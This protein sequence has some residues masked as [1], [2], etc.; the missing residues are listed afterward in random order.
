MPYSIHR[1]CLPLPATALPRPPLLPA[2][3]SD[4]LYALAMW[5]VFP[6]AGGGRAECMPFPA[7]S[8]DSI[9]L[10]A[11]CSALVGGSEGG[12]RVFKCCLA[13]WGDLFGPRR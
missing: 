9:L 4:M 13:G 12:G 3:T 8:F 1:C 7:E 11:P 2:T 6:A 5:L 10:D